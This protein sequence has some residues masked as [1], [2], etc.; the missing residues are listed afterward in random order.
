MA[1]A[2]LDAGAEALLPP[3][4]A[5]Q[6][7]EGLTGPGRVVIPAFLTPEETALLAFEC[8]NLYRQDAFHHARVGHG[9]TLSLQPKLRSDHV[10]WIDPLQPSPLQQGYLDRVQAIQRLINRN[11]FLG[12]EEF[13]C[14]FALYPPDSFYG[15]HL[16]RF[17]DDSRRTV[18]C[19]LYLNNGWQPEDGG[20]LRIYLGPGEVPFED[21]Q[22]QGGTLVLFL[23]DAFEH[24]VLPSTRERLSLTGWFLQR[25]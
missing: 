19:I 18:T 14:H 16:D 25:P 8:Q 20:M 1:L 12:L 11:L 24:E 4:V 6:I 15:R 23:S 13:E 21:V 2:A 17:A 9:S 10:C 5:D 7:I 3:A 22:P